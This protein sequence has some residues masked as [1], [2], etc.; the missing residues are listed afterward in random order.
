MKTFDIY[1]DDLTEECQ[2]RLSEFLE[3]DED[4]GDGNFSILPLAEI[5]VEDQI[6]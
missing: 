2:K 6:Q 1:W 5:N 3:L 4:E